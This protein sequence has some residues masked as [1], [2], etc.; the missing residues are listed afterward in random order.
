MAATSHDFW[1]KN[2]SPRVW[3]G[4]HMLVYPAWA[5]LVLH[6]AL[7]VLQSETNPAYPIMLGIAVL[8]VP[9]LH[10]LAGTK[11]VR[12][13]WNG[14]DRESEWVDACALA[15]LQEARGKSVSLPGG[16][17]VAVFRFNGKIS[18]ISNVCA[19]QGGPLGEGRIID[20]C[21]TCPW[22]GYQYRPGDGCAPPP[23]TE[24]L[25]TYRVRIGDGRVLVSRES[26]P[27]GTAVEP[28]CIN[29]AT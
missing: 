23:F 16:E 27:P 13:D 1:L 8:V 18:A 28:A 14:D 3:K 29:G 21:I 24:K 6:I 7:G 22:H 26:L 9:G 19:H 25:P 20:G 10:V 15:D 17:R 5:L 11:E 4:L 12:R 2:L